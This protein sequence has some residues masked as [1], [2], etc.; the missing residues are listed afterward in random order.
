MAYWVPMYPETALSHLQALE[1]PRAIVEPVLEGF[2]VARMEEMAAIDRRAAALV[3]EILRLLAAGGK[4][5]R[6]AFCYWGYRAGGGTEDATIAKAAAALELFH[7]FALIHDDLMDESDRRRG[8]PSVHVRLAEDHPGPADRAE[9][10]GRSGAILIGDLA[11]VLADELLLASEVP[12]DRLLA[13]LRRYDQMRIEV[14]AGQFLDV[15]GVARDEPSALRVAALKTGAYTVE[16]PLHIGAILAGASLEAMAGLSA[17]ARPLGEAFQ[18][19]D[20]VL[21][22]GEGSAPGATAATVDELLDRADAALDGPH[23]VPEAVAA[24]RSLGGALRL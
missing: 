10:Y 20:D 2:L 14:A 21:D 19:R 15:A 7:T 1:R 22:H 16:G 3:G 5:I 18:L 12:A 8:V 6:P 23:L 4:R 9:R 13:A 24:L 11:A 17:Y